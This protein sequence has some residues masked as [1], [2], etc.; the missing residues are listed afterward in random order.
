MAGTAAKREQQQPATRR[1][2]PKSI[3]TQK[4]GDTVCER[5]GRGEPLAA[6]CREL[7]IGRQTVHDWRATNPQFNVQ[8]ARARDNGYDAIA[9]Q[10]LE[11]ADDERKDWILTKKG[12]LCDETAVSRARLMVESRLKLLAKWDPARYG[13]RLIEDKEVRVT[14][15]VNDPTASVRASR[16]IE[17]EVSDNATQT[18]RITQDDQ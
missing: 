16:I 6:V 7:G 5:V 9:E 18:R 2:G 1:R 15:T 3:Y 4:L 12:T 10:V 14:V 8:F 13:D 11:I 17:H